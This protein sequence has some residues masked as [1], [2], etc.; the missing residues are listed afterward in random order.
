MRIVTEATL[1]SKI[2]VICT[3]WILLHQIHL[4]WNIFCFQHLFVN[5]SI[6]HPE[7]PLCAKFCFF[8]QLQIR[9]TTAGRGVG[10]IAHY[11]CN[12]AWPGHHHPA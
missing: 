8:H 12:L 3:S 1:N 4:V 10:E 6:F 7:R 11:N 9:L 5:F 2:V